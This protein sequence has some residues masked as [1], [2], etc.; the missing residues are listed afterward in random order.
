MGRGF[1]TFRGVSPTTVAADSQYRPR[2]V[3]VPEEPDP[4]LQGEV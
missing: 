1:E 4:T 3:P 2:S